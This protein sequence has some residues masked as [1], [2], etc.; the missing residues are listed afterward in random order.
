MKDIYNNFDANN[1]YPCSKNTKSKGF[2]LLMFTIINSNED[3]VKKILESNLECIND[4][5][6]KGWTALMI[7]SR[8][9]KLYGE[10][11]VKILIDSGANLDI[12]NNDGW[13]ALMI[14]SRY[15]NEDSTENTVQIL[16]D[17]GANLDIQNNYGWTTLMLAAKYS[18]E[19][20]VKMLIDSGA[21]VNDINILSSSLKEYYRDKK[22][23]QMIQTMQ[24]MINN[25]LKK[26][27][28]DF[29]KELFEE[30]YAPNEFGY[31][32]AKNHFDQNKN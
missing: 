28:K 23:Q 24:N 6:D 13:T 10:N 16:I 21:K 14:A 20:T 29:K 8:N 11:I 32:M 30:L 2:T 22:E 15:P 27:K 9:T 12:Q 1:E 5:N 3:E 19:N 7:A 4:K 18:T 31:Q 25:S 17:A 26:F